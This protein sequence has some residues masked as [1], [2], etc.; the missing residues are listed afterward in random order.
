MAHQQA[1]TSFYGGRM[2]ATNVR[3]DQ[4]ITQL[5]SRLTKTERD[6]KSSHSRFEEEKKLVTSREEELLKA[7]AEVTWIHT[8]MYCN[9]AAYS[10]STC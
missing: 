10:L 9:H 7:K 3:K 5:S 6:L 4:T 8:S 2:Q 1:A